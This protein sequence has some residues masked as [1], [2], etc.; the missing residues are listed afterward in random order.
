MPRKER[1]IKLRRQYIVDVAQELF[2]KYGYENTSMDDIAKES[3]FSKT[4]LYKYFKSKEELSIYV[5]RKIHLEKMAVL[6][7][8]IDKGKTGADKLYQ[9]AQAYI[10]F[11]A[12]NPDAL[13]FQLS[14]DY[15]GINKEII[16]KE[17]VEE[18]FSSYDYDFVYLNDIIVLGKKDGSFREDLD[19]EA[20]LDT[21]YLLLRSLLNQMLFIKNNNNTVSSLFVDER[22]SYDS[23]VEI[24]IKGLKPG[25]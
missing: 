15:K 3:E 5:Y 22:S 11:F 7:S 6:R 10:K 24:F 25:I 21:Y 1:E 16:S 4:T 9:F 13:R 20:V 17:Q 14:W 19:N 23:F 18:I 2:K 8:F 12:E